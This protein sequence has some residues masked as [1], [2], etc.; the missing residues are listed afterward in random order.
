MARG[1]GGRNGSK[2]TEHLVI[3]ISK[4]TRTLPLATVL[5]SAPI[6]NHTVLAQSLG[7]LHSFGGADGAFPNALLVQATDGN[8]YG[9]TVEGGANSSGTV[10]RM[11]PDGTLTTFYS[12]CAQTGCTDGANPYAGLIQD[13]NGNLYGT[14]N[15]GGAN[16]SGTVFQLDLGG[17]LTTLYSFCAK[18]GCTDGAN[19]EAALIQATNGDLYGT[20]Y[21]GGTYGYGTAFRITPSGTLTT[22]HNFSKMS[23]AAGLVEAGNG[24]FYG[25]TTGTTAKL[26][27]TVFEMNP[28]GRL[29]TLYKFCSQSACADGYQPAAG[30]IQASNGDLYGTTLDGGTNL[31]GTGTAFQ[32]TPGGV[33]TTIDSFCSVGAC[34]NGEYPNAGLI[35]AGD[36]NF[37]GTT[38]GGGASG[39]GTIFQITPGGTLTTLYSF[40]SLPNC[41]DGYHPMAGLTQDTNGIL[42]GTTYDGGVNS[43]GTVYSLS[44]G[45]SPFVEFQT[46]TGRV[47]SVVNILGTDLTGA[48]GVTFNGIA[49]KFTV[50][51]ADEITAK[52]P[53]GTTTGTIDVITPSGAITSS[54]SFIEHT[55]VSGAY[56]R[57]SAQYTAYPGAVSANWVVTL[58][59]VEQGST[60][61]VVGV[62]PNYV[63]TYPTMGVTDGT[64]T[65]TLLDR[66]DDLTLF[67]MG[68][69]GT[70]SMGHWYAANVPAGSYR[71]DMS[72]TPET[73]EDW[74]G[75]VA[76]EIAGASAS[77]IEGHTL[78][79]Q[80]GVPPGKNSVEATVTNVIASGLLLAVTYDDIDYTVPTVPLVGGGYTDAGSLWNYNSSGWTNGY[81]GR[82]ESA[83]VSSAGSHVATF[84]PEEGGAQNP[85]YMTTAVIFSA[86]AP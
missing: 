39:S 24:D 52:V 31:N 65:Y 49:A 3:S 38:A 29:T 35:Q 80:A 33:L 47:G 4:W 69:Q 23:P 72:S 57:Q 61:Y 25:T 27:G 77:P 79:F 44:M 60:I 43:L 73:W 9:T 85:D 59:N 46:T 2:G 11:T 21:H 19:P 64:N 81:S 12:F 83:T 7:T 68:M 62:W 26:P 1:P 86:T 76:F 63:N 58:P 45:L 34:A 40:C 13:T 55:P 15:A 71:I 32:I 53:Q 6:A 42:Y 66:Y 56:I 70:E 78:N 28:G 36:G 14:T 8:L 54:Q 30:L 50:V 67:N 82:A 51:S 84:S 10:F 48:T 41:T 20:T 16:N 17:S 5:A 18:S 74:V 37:Y 75:V 22:L